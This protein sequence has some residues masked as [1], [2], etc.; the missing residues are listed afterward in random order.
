MLYGISDCF[1]FPRIRSS[2]CT[3]NSEVIVSNIIIDSDP[4]CLAFCQVDGRP[5]GSAIEYNGLA[6][7]A[8]RSDV[9]F[10]GHKHIL[11][12]KTVTMSYSK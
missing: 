8:V 9:L 5:G 6:G 1:T 11:W 2:R 3:Y 4:S 7:M 12:L 10:R